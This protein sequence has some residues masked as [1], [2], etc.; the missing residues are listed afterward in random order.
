MEGLEFF[1]EL[2]VVAFTA[3][4][5]RGFVVCTTTCGPVL[6]SYVA[7]EYDRGWLNGLKAGLIFNLPRIALITIVGAVLGY[8][9]NILISPWFEDS[10][11]SL[12]VFGY[13]IF[14]IYVIFL[15]LGMYGKTKEHT[16]GLLHRALTRI[17]SHYSNKNGVLL[18]MGF[19][20]GA[21]CLLEVSILDA[22]IL[23]TASGIFGASTGVPT[24]ITGA[25]TMFVFGLGS[26]VP[27]LLITIGSGEIS[28]FIPD[29]EI[30]N[31][32]RSMMG[33]V[34]IMVG[35]F[36]IFSRYP[37]ILVMLQ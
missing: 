20:I 21:V 19:L 15:G 31:K 11:A 7:T 2:L 28:T 10:L 22:V 9:S 36:I 34:L 37:A 17:N 3:G 29:K 23:S 30:L 16:H 1:I 14:A 13:I 24:M 6:A 27:L 32:A 25:L 26:M 33:V 8:L 18:F 4:A 12:F 35:I 5:T